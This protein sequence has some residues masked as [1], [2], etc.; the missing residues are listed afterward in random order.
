MPPF[1]LKSPTAHS[2]ASFGAASHHNSVS[3]IN[4]YKRRENRSLLNLQM[5]TS[6][7]YLSDV[8]NG[9]HVS[10]M[11]ENSAL[12]LA[13][14]GSFSAPNSAGEESA[15]DS[16]IP[17]HSRRREGSSE[18]GRRSMTHGRRR[19]ALKKSSSQPQSSFAT[20]LLIN[21]ESENDDD[22]D[23]GAG[24]SE[25]EAS[26]ASANRSLSS[27]TRKLVSVAKKYRRKI[28]KKK[29][30]SKQNTRNRD[31][32]C[33][34]DA[35]V[36]DGSN[37]GAS[38]E[39]A[40]S[41]NLVKAD[42]SGWSS[43]RSRARSKKSV[44]S[45]PKDTD[46]SD[47]SDASDA[48]SARKK[49]A[50]G[51]DY[52]GTLA[53]K[54]KKKMK[55]IMKSLHVTPSS[56]LTFSTGTTE[57]TAPPSPQTGFDD[58]EYDLDSRL[59]P[60]SLSPDS[61]G[62]RYSLRSAVGDGGARQ[63]HTASVMQRRDLT[64]NGSH[65]NTSHWSHRGKRSYMEDRYAIEELGVLSKSSSTRGKASRDQEVVPMTWFAVFDGH[66]GERASQF[67]V[68]WLSSYV[69]HHQSFPSDMGTVLR[70][71]FRSVDVD[72][73]ST[74]LQDGTTACT[75][76]VQGRKRLYCA[77]AGDS[78][79]IVVRQDGSVVRLS[80]DHKPGLLDETKRITDLGGKV[81]YWGRW[82]VEGLLA[83]SRS[84]GDASLKPYITADPEICEYEIEESDM[85]LVIASDGIWD[86]LSNEQVA[87]LVITQS[88]YL[89]DDCVCSDAER[90]KW[91]ARKLCEKA[92]KHGSSDNFAAVVTDL[93]SG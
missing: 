41:K 31:A 68:D 46:T 64:P 33:D 52:G 91:T 51:K 81:I 88:C 50:Q 24:W 10:N 87:K 17:L 76:L 3:S 82:R 7:A 69:R 39:S 40:R 35:D 70:D 27:S 67:C 86:V 61:V 9:Y 22:C 29:K 92:K 12:A 5:V 38:T 45:E 80:R 72:F 60:S 1:N 44:N 16:D 59:V 49:K 74:G 78:R 58:M 2:L 83:V 62:L 66:G 6:D 37:S 15:C 25:S 32:S 48:N 21:E 8:E 14:S 65:L 28:S 43:W 63:P 79:A 53:D 85:F 34:S 23:N 11:E 54:S 30:T 47:L 56:S 36:S 20:D 57:T 75:C 18:G 26:D 89:Q 93:R 71:S 55:S 77:N 42:R 90:L 73:V 19:R 13:A 4:T 84:I